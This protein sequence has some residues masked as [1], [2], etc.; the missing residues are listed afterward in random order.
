[1][2]LTSLAR[3]SSPLLGAYISFPSPFSA[4]LLSRLSFPWALI[5][6]EH[7]PLSPAT[8]TSLVHAIAAGSR[9]ATLPLVRIPS[10]AVEWVKWALDSGAAGIVAPMVQCAEEAA[11]LVRHARYPPEGWRSVGPFQ[12]G[13]ADVTGEGGV[14][15]Y[16]AKAG[17][18]DG[19][20]LIV[21]IESVLGVENSGE[22]MRTKGVSGVFVGPVDLRA[23]L[24]LPGSH[25]EE[26][27]Y[28]KALERVIRVGKEIGMPVG[29]FSTGGEALKAH[30]KMGFSFMLVTGD[31]MAL[32]EG[33]SAALRISMQIVN[34]LKTSQ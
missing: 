7:A 13:G 23:S 17:R 9:N 34:E 15:A 16:L 12:A 14:G 2:S 24:G 25:G 26:E 30:V 4:H 27:V 19:V 31:V 6:M 5:D 28:M 33:A 18:E 20:D 11:A 32:T 3:T 22:I 8:M 10:H 29:I 21:M 1:M